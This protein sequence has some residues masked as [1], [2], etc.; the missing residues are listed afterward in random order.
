[1]STYRIDHFGVAVPDIDA[2]VAEY[3]QLFGYR[4]L[5]GPYDDPAQQARV[6]F[7]GTAC[8]HDTPVELVA[9]L[10]ANSQ[11]HRVLAKGMGLYHV[12]Y[13]VPDIEKA[14]SEL[15]GQRCLLVSGPTPAVA[16]EGRPIA[17]LYTPGRQ[18]TELVE[19]PRNKSP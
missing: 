15:R 18:L 17:W 8:G 2:A 9:P 1:M 3:T 12:C 4:L 11:V 14:I 6:A 5:R 13:E 7:V 10:D 16:Y 19:A